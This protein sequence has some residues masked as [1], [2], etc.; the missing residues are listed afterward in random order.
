MVNNSTMNIFLY[1]NEHNDRLSLILVFF[2]LVFLL[3]TPFPLAYGQDSGVN[4][5]PLITTFTSEEYNAG[6]QNWTMVQ[7]PN[8]MIYLGNN[9]GLLEFDGN[10]WRQA[11]VANGT[12]IRS[13]KIG[14]DDRIY[15]GA[16][17]EFGYFQYTAQGELQYVSVS[18]LLEK[19]Y[20]VDETWNVFLLNDGVYYCTFR[21]I[22]RYFEGKIEVIDPGELIGFSFLIN[23]RIYFQIPGKGIYQ[24]ENDRTFSK[25]ENSDFFADK[26]VRG[27]IPLSSERLLVIT[28]N[29]GIYIHSRNKN[30]IWATGT[31]NFFRAS[32][33]NTAIQ[34]GSG[35]FAIGTQNEGLLIL[36]PA[37][38]LL[39]KIGETSG[40]DRSVN[41]LYEDKQGNLWASLHN[42][43]S[44]VELGLPFG[45]ISDN[46]GISGSGY[47]AALYNDQVYIGTNNNVYR[48]Q[49]NNP[50]Q[51]FKLVENSQG[52]SYSLQ[53]FQ[54]ELLLSHHNGTFSLIKDG[55][56]KIA[57]VDGTWMFVRPE[58]HPDKL[59]GGYYNGLFLLTRENDQWKFS[60]RFGEFSESCRV[61]VEDADQNIWM[62]HGY[63]GVYRIRFSPDLKIIEDVHYFN[64]KDGFPSNFLINV[65][66]INGEILF[67][68]ERGIYVFQAAS[69]RFILHPQ[70]NEHFEPSTHIREME[71][72][73][74]GNIYYIANDEAGYLKKDAY[75][76]YTKVQ[77]V[78]NKIMP[79]MNDALENITVIDHRTVL[80]SA[81][82]GFISFDPT[83][84][85]ELPDAPR[86]LIR[87]LSITSD[88]AIQVSES[89]VSQPSDSS[90]V[91]SFRNNSLKINFSS[92]FYGMPNRTSYRILL[93]NF[94]RD[95]SGWSTATT[96]EY[97]NLPE[98]DYV[99]K[100][101]SR[102]IYGQLSVPSAFTFTIR[103]PWFRSRLAYALYILLSAGFLLGLVI[104]LERKHSRE[105]FRLEHEQKLALEKR[106]IQ[107]EALSI[108]ST[109]EITRLRNEKLQAELEHKNQEL[110]S[111]AMQII[112]K[113]EFIG[114]LKQSLNGLSKRSNNQSLKK[115]F[116]RI[117]D[118]IEKNI[119]SNQDWEQFEIHFDKVHGNFSERLKQDFPDLTPQEM[120]LAAYLRMNL[121]TKEIAQ[122][123]NISVRGVEIARY[124]LRKKLNL[125]RKDNLSE[126]I[127]KY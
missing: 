104:V 81:K 96:K 16:Q 45:R 119:A 118:E 32:L 87:S 94:D 10:H 123:L 44:L 61:L 53:V 89:L 111:A 37:G 34:L 68:A 60:H 66:K 83:R 80:F 62:S 110:G 48:W 29:Q 31:D 25:L 90:Y 43:V 42:G 107:Y 112:S 73:N 102:N 39:Y 113:N 122:M 28:H 64:E 59:I 97:T 121:S 116:S 40:L 63:K 23:N 91:F 77:A 75:G 76:G 49:R 27:L 95:W 3:Y 11:P 105:K 65:F 56:G 14:Q 24:L 98:G 85:F 50:W 92:P 47:A 108:Q 79:Y 103:P 9:M 36:D 26:S 5:V 82:N 114:H 15:A 71:M 100:V 21:Y 18:S 12:K 19:K 67:A 1:Y 2:I 74:R 38:N 41:H 13:L 117:I 72:D 126:F 70:L 8:G 58:K 57:D 125:E 88:S 106:E 46:V 33:V 84:H 17:D 93:E 35:N 30:E 4:S 86:V 20:P 51:N 115:D 6:I 101:Q 124:R 54:N 127:L 69:N 55:F 78:F 120:K 99:F 7:H 52:Q 109:E 22:F